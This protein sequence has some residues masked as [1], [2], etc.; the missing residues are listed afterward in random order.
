MLF[1]GY[2]R[3]ARSL[4][5]VL[6]ELTFFCSFRNPVVLEKDARNIEIYRFMSKGLL[7]FPLTG[8]ILRE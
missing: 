3:S 2:F 8:Y 5:T 6:T 1:L 4:V 7:F